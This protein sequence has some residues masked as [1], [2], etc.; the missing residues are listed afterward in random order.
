M[1]PATSH[2]LGVRVCYLELRH[3]LAM[4]LLD[5]IMSTFALEVNRERLSANATGQT[6]LAAADEW[7]ER[8]RR[9]KR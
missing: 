2:P 1:K 5:E 4:E 7:N 9:L 3:E 6:L 8:Y